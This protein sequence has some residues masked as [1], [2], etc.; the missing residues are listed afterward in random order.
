MIEV[1]GSKPL[2]SFNC[3][4]RNRKTNNGPVMAA[5]CGNQQD[6]GRLWT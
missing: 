1:S 2:E 6:P 3:M 5:I 4:F